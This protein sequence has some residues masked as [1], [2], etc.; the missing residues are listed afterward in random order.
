MR[1][2]CVEE[3]NAGGVLVRAHELNSI[4]VQTSVFQHNLRSGVHILGAKN[5]ARVQRNRIE[6]TRGPALVL[7]ICSSATVHRNDL[8]RNRLGILSLGCSPTITFNRVTRNREDGI[9]TQSFQ[10]YGYILFFYS[11]FFRCYA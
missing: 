1:N 10:G 2:C 5:K 6:H 4:L 8:D 7:D 3:H 11:Y 9:R